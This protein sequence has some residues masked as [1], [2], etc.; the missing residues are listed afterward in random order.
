[1]VKRNTTI[2]RRI[3]KD[4]KILL[5]QLR[6][7]PIIQLAVKDTGI[8]RTSY[9]RWCK[10]DKKFARSAQEAIRE[11][12]LFVN[13]IA[14]SQ[15]LQLIKEKKLE[16]IRLWLRHH[17]PLYTEK[18][19]IIGNVSHTHELTK[20]QRATIRKALRL[21]NLNKKHYVQ[22]KKSEGENPREDNQ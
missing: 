19:K 4:K 21:V 1:M 16:A 6:K 15:L 12:Y 5:E 17:H 14:E 9:Y 11:G 2:D 10:Q 20:E 7:T 18:L 22:I 13:D 3:N 8:G